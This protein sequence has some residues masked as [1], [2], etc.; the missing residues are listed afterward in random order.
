MGHCVGALSGH[1]RGTVRALSGHCKNTWFLQNQH[2]N[3]NRNNNRTISC[4]RFF[5][6]KKSLSKKLQ[7]GQGSRTGQDSSGQ[8][9]QGQ[10]RTGQEQDK[11]G[12][13]RKGRDR[14]EQDRTDV[15]FLQGCAHLGSAPPVAD[16][17]AS[18]DFLFKGCVHLG[19]AFQLLKRE[20]LAISKGCLHLVRASSSTAEAPNQKQKPKK[21]AQ[22]GY[23]GR[24]K[25]C[26][27]KANHTIQDV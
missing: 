6:H 8:H 17:Q 21:T 3:N 1:C 25:Y 5:L 19:S 23:W 12:R 27:Q 4:K 13:D 7:Q 16:A 14:T 18:R 22:R 24:K 2:V 10:E 26:N 11:T 9:R 20:S 15:Y